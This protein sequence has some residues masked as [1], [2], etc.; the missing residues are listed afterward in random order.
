MALVLYHH[1]FSRAA[2]VLWMLEELG[3]D[4]ELRYVDF[5]AQAQKQPEFLKLNPMGKLPVLIDDGIVITE[6]A[7]IGIYLADRYSSG[8]LAPTLDDPLRGPYLRWSFFS[9][10]VVEPNL[11][12]KASG[13]EYRASAVGWGT[14]EAVLASLDHALTPGPYLLGERFSM[15]DIILGG[16][17]RYMIRFK[18]LEPSPLVRAYGLRLD[19][20]PAVQ[21]SEARNMAI[22]KERGLGG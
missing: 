9:P 4:A 14:H 19:E 17:L 10:S 22:A 21:R 7:A 8:K 20:R 6:V 12:A 11:A 13:F 15:A 16:T 3:L 5:A 1:P 2:A 18:M